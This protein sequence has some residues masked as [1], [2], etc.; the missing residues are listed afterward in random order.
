[1]LRIAVLFLFVFALRM[2]SGQDISFDK[3]VEQLF[4]NVDVSNRSVSPVKAFIDNKLLSYEKP[5]GYTEY[6]FIGK[7]WRH[8]FVFTKHPSLKSRFNKGQIEVRIVDNGMGEKVDEIGWSLWF[9][10]KEDA[11]KS[12]DELVKHLKTAGTS[13]NMN[14]SKLAIK[15]G[16]FSDTNSRK[17][18]SLF[19]FLG[20]NKNSDE[21]YKI[22]LLLNIKEE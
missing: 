16:E 7:S 8:N 4:F 12:F 17:Y 20:D 10:K 22:V 6:P 15:E 19:L 3:K 9:H 21:M 14:R 1:M 2:V 5:E 11:L 18:S 13:I